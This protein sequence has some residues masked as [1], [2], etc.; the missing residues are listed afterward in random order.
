MQDLKASS[1]STASSG[2]AGYSPP[3]SLT[4]QISLIMGVIVGKPIS[5]GRFGQVFHGT[6]NGCAVALKCIT[7]ED[8]DE[9]IREADML[10]SLRHPN[11]VQFMGIFNDPQGRHYIVT[12]F[13]VGGNLESLLRQNPNMFTETDLVRLARDAAAGMRLLEQKD[14]VHRDLAA[15]NLLVDMSKS[16]YS[17]KV[18]DFGLSRDAQYAKLFGATGDEPLPIRW[19]SP[20]VLRYRMFSGKSDVWSMGIVMWEIMNHG[21]VPYYEMP[22]SD[23][24]DYVLQGK[25]MTFSPTTNPKI[26]ELAYQCW[27][28]DPDDRPTFVQIFDVLSKVIAGVDCNVPLEAQTTPRK[29]NMMRDE[30]LVLYDDCLS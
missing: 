2:D 14:I 15:R 7:T 1:S 8:Y 6:W 4:K 10:R 16:I 25:R 5:S 23:V 11:I 13:V 3:T 12:E 29:T 26:A 20:E 24:I 17:V 28:M 9:T 27:E 19:L 21:M 22:N 30:S 18:A